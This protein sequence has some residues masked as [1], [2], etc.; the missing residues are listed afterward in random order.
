M[1]NKINSSNQQQSDNNKIDAKDIKK[2]LMEDNKAF[3]LE[4]QKLLLDIA[5]AQTKEEVNT[6]LNSLNTIL[7]KVGRTLNDIR[8]K[9]NTRLTKINVL[10]HQGVLSGNISFSENGDIQIARGK[11]GAELTRQFHKYR[12]FLEKQNKLG[13]YFTR[14]VKGKK[15]TFSATRD[16]YVQN[17]HKLATSYFSSK[18][19]NN[20]ELGAKLAD[21]F[22]SMMQKAFMAGERTFSLSTL[23]ELNQVAQEGGFI[24]EEVSNKLLIDEFTQAIKDPKVLIEGGS[25]TGHVRIAYRIVLNKKTKDELKERG[26]I[27]RTEVNNYFDELVEQT[28]ELDKIDDYINFTFKAK[29]QQQTEQ[30]YT[31]AFSDKMYKNLKNISIITGLNKLESQIS[32]ASTLLNTY[33]LIDSIGAQADA[34][35]FSALNSSTASAFYNPNNR[36]S[37]KNELTKLF[38]SFI[39]ET[40]YNP[41][42][43]VSQVLESLNLGAF[44]EI[45][46]NFLHKL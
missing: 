30:R 13:T 40:A 37:I 9:I 15:D 26:E 42:S 17:I 43:F 7:E 12:D 38:S 8:E 22:V 32:G 11:G 28:T 29:N 20:F 6:I 14:G 34:F 27:L 24:W 18:N 19:N 21:R 45:S 46:E 33:D 31:I 44:N 41:D 39:Y 3:N 35:V 23:E 2:Q 10:Q 5:N 16:K 1:I 36:E 4:Y 25:I